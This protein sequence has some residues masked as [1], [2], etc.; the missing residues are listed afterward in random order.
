M[1]VAEN[2]KPESS[3]RLV[4]AAACAGAFA[5]A[6]NTTAVMTAL[7][8]IRSSLDLDADTLQWVINLYMLCT[9]ATLA[10][11]VISPIRSA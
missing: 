11:W 9:A 7:P 10:A 1:R 6:Y 2:S 4:V 5:V 3:F 8:A